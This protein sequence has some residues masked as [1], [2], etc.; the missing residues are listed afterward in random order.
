MH[1][2]LMSN[3]RELE[4]EHLRAHATTVKLDMG[5]WDTCRKDPKQEAEVRK[6]M[7]DG[8]KVGV[9]GT[10]A[11]FINGIMLSGALPFEQFKEIIDR[12]LDKG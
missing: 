4:E 7:E 1:N 11:F 10:P 9:S 2:L 6:D 12:E 3:Q 5:K 8:A